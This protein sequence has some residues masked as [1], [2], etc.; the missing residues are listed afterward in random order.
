[1]DDYE[2]ERELLG[3]YLRHI[4]GGTEQNHE[5]IIPVAYKSKSKA[6]PVTGRGGL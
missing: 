2:L 1:L 3:R 4:P 6:I 5:I